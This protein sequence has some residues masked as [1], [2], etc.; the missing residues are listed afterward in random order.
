MTSTNVS[1]CISCV[2]FRL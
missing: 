1:L 2:R